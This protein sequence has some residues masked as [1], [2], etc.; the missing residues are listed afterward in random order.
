LLGTVAN[1]ASLP[2]LGNSVND[3][4]IVEADGDLY[5][6]SGSAWSSVGQIVG[7]TGPTGPSVTGPTGATGPAS[8]IQG[9]TGPTGSLGPTGPKGGTTF[10]ISSTG[11]GGLYE[12]DGLV[13]GNPQLTA[14]RGERVYFDVSGVLA[15]NSLALRFTS[16]STASIPGTSNN[17]TVAGRN[18]F[19]ANTTIIWDV[20]FDA[21][22]QIIYRDTSDANIAGIIVVVDKIGPT[23]P[24]GAQGDAGVPTLTSYTPVFAG[25]GTTFTGDPASGEYLEY[26]DSVSFALSINFAEFSN[27]GTGQYSIT[28]PELPSTS[29]ATYYSFSGI[30]DANG[31]NRYEIVAYS[32]TGGAVLS[33]FFK[34]AGSILTPL[35]GAV[36]ATLTTASFI[37]I[38]GTYISEQV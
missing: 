32:P 36:P 37:S 1:V 31:T 18:Q 26:G 19:S 24:T 14:V 2:A 20:P 8:N 23:G 29:T 4:Y 3:A 11:E 17:D 15:T 30:L 5:V 13:G 27:F 22:S 33:L 12:V 25:T 9:P 28:L 35:T 21:P 6:W 7:P 38:T 10:L 16:T 34:G